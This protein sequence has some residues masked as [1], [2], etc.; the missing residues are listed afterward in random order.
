MNDR[1]KLPNRRRHQNL[2]FDLDGVKFTAGIS[3]YADGRL[4]EVFFHAAGK[5]GSAVERFAQDCAVAASLALQRG[6]TVGE[7]RHSLVKL[8]DG[9][10]AGPLGRLLDLIDGPGHAS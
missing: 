1:E 2:Y 7:L 9:R 10:G 6:A 5:P 3:R 4:A 8:S